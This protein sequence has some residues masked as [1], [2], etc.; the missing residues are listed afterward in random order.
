MRLIRRARPQSRAGS[1]SSRQRRSRRGQWKAPSSATGGPPCLVCCHHE[2]LDHALHPRSPEALMPGLAE[3]NHKHCACAPR[4]FDNRL[5]DA[6]AWQ[7]CFLPS[8]P[9]C[10]QSGDAHLL[11]LPCPSCSGPAGSQALFTWNR[12]Y[13]GAVMRSGSLVSTGR[14]VSP[15]SGRTSQ[16]SLRSSAPARSD[17]QKPPGVLSVCAHSVQATRAERTAAFCI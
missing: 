2:P 12:L 15:A 17:A 3:G 5:Q 7:A 6:S 4:I 13:P 11:K 14:P 9:A 8:S 10:I 1:S 16:T